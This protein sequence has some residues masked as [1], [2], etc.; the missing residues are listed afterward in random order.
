MGKAAGGTQLQRK[1]LA[2]AQAGVDVEHDRK[3]QLRFF[4]EDRNF[5]GMTVFEY[6]EIILIKVGDRRAVLVGDGDEDI[7]QLDVNF[8][9][10]GVVN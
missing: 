10:A 4:S 7:D 3:R 6:S 8:D 9:I 1:I 2:R 5:L